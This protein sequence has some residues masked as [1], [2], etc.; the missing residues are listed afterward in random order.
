MPASS[1]RGTWWWPC[2]IFF[3]ALKTFT[4]PI[5]SIGIWSPAT[6]SL[7]T[8]AASKFVTLESLVLCLIAASVRVVALQRG[9]ETPSASKACLRST[10]SNS[11]VQSLFPKLTK[12]SRA[13]KIKLALFHLTSDQDGTELQRSLLSRSNMTKRLTCGQSDVFCGSS[14]SWS[15]T[16]PSPVNRRDQCFSRET[17]AS[18]YLLLLNRETR[19]TRA[20]W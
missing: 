18:H 6:F 11:Y 20:I 16:R 13:L 5:S 8:N 9:S 7:T 3:A 2:I 15:K 17:L 1:K 14:W 12:I 4:L 19:S 10:V